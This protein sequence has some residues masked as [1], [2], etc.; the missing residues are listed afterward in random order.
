MGRLSSSQ[1]FRVQTLC[2]VDSVPSCSGFPPFYKPQIITRKIGPLPGQ[3]PGVL[4][5]GAAGVKPTLA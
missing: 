2:Y 4:R 5:E 1:M 3:G